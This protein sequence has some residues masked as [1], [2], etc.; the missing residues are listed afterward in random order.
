M[1]D[2]SIPFKHVLMHRPA[3]TPVP[4]A[5]LPPGYS[6]RLFRAGDEKGWAI[7]EASVLE[8]PDAIDALLYFQRSF[9]PYLSELERRVGFIVD[10][11]DAIV[12]T[13]T[14]WWAYKG[15]R[16]D[17][18]VDWVSVSPDHQGKGLGQAAFSNVLERIIRIEGDRDIYLHTQTWSHTAIRIYQKAGFYITPEPGL[19]GYSNED[20]AGALA[21][22]E[23]FNIKAKLTRE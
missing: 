10:E 15:E 19:R 16:R 23:Q 18:W 1:L 6:F 2:K 3:G 8:F 22:L 9:M 11:S 21:I 12:A 20:Y 7:L 5:P 17:P 14:A 13:A 4:P